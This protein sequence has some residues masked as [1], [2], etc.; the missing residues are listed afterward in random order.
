MRRV[1]Q[2]DLTPQSGNCFAA[3]VAS[4]LNMEIK[5]VPNFCWE[6]DQY[7]WFGAFQKW[8][9]PKGLTAIEIKYG[10]GCMG[11]TTEGIPCIISGESGNCDGCLHS[12]VGVVVQGGFEFI[13]DPN[14]KGGFLKS[15]PQQILFF[16]VLRPDI[17]RDLW[18]SRSAISRISIP[19]R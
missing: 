12:V 17:V 4:I 1:Y 10:P 9:E 7:K 8:L 14:P 18:R 11:Q 3:C 2:T 16:G 6:H 13:H 15:D 19:H 5:D